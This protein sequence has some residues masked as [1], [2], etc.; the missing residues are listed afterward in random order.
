MISKK[1]MII[2]AAIF[3]LVG[4]SQLLT[5]SFLWIKKL[6]F[7]E[8]LIGAAIGILIGAIKFLYLFKK[9][10]LKNISR[11]MKGDEKQKILSVFK[12]KT[13]VIILGMIFLGISLR[14]ILNISRVYLFPVYLAIGLALLL[15]SIMYFVYYFRH[16]LNND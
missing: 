9:L 4:A 6:N 14:V 3:Y 11:I 15:S 10:N 5:F 12:V 2:T 8:I 1:S 7:V 13:Y 16:S